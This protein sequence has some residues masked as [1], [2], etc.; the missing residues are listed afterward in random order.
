MKGGVQAEDHAIIY[1][2]KRA[3]RPL[4]GEDGMVKQPL[5]VHAITKRDTLSPES[6]INYGKVYTVEYG[7]AVHFIGKV[8]DENLTQLLNDFN[9]VWE[10]GEI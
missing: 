3:P 7:V 6:R 8:K 5:R 10:E 4:Y 9:S 1:M 2:G